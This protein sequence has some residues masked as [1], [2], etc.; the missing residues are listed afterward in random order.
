MFPRRTLAE[1]IG[2][3]S[4]KMYATD[5]RQ[6]LLILLQP[7]RVSGDKGSKA[8]ERSH[9]SKKSALMNLWKNNAE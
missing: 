3:D 6:T 2:K 4:G 1:A 5:D 7:T 9:T 8:F